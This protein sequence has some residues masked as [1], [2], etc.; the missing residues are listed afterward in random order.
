[1]ARVVVIGGS[2]HVG[3]YL[4]PALVERGH[5]VVNVSRGQANRYQ[6]HAAWNAIENVVADRTVEENAGTFGSTIAALRPDVVVDMISFKLSST[7]S[8]VHALSGKVEHFLHCSTIWV[9]G[10]NAAVPAGED[11]PLNPFG[12]Y[13][14][15]KAA[16]ETWLMH[17]ARKTGFPATIFRPG[18]IVGVGWVPINPVGNINTEVFS[19]IAR[20]EELTL[21][22]FGLETLH[23]V[24]ADDVSQM[25]LLAMGNRSASLGEAF[26]VVSAKALNLRGYAEAMFR[27]F[28]FEP[29]LRFEHFEKWKARHS[30]DDAH[31]SWEHISRSSCMSI[32]K[33]RSR[34]GYEPRYSSLAAIQEA[35]AALITA[36]KVQ[37][38]KGW[39][40]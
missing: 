39:Q 6:H 13:G 33:A 27:W 18:H 31:Q 17:E 26:N 21:P 37:A 10:H 30:S 2:G 35:V 9:F 15:N 4:L 40:R 29:K 14:I 20:N 12:E 3:T 24:H 8:L 32:D 5:D 16:I 7:Q 11:D 28:G 25:I 19:C 36:G 1:M 34:L 38:P 22:N 23:H